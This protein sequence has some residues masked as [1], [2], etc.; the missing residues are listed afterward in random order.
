MIALL[1]L[2]LGIDLPLVFIGFHFGYRK[3]A[4]THPVRTNQIPR[5]VPEQP[6]YLKTLPCALIAGVL[7]FGAVFIEL[8]FIF[9]AI[10]ENQFYYLFG[11]LWLVMGILFISCAQIAIVVTYFLLCA[12]NYHWWWKSFNVSCGSALYVFAYSVYYYYTKVSYSLHKL[13]VILVE[14][15]RFCPHLVVLRVQWHDFGHFC[16]S[17]WY[18][19]ILRRLRFPPT[20][21]WCSQD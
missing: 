7:P 20:N 19:R 21:L 3:Q 10:W 18:C 13:K 2:W 16:P 9:S 1:F 11:F 8:Y 14:H 4:Y 17:H 15:R 6:W 5:Q 12:E